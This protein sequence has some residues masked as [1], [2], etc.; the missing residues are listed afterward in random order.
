MSQ[1][2]LGGNMQKKFVVA[3][4]TALGI[5]TL[6]VGATG[7]NAAPTKKAKVSLCAGKTKAAAIKAINTAYASVLDGSKGLTGEQK[8]EFIQF[9]SGKKLNQAWRDAFLA[10]SAKNTGAAS[11]TSVA[12][13]KVT[14]TGKKSADVVFTLVLGGSRAEGLAPP[15][16]AVL[17][18]NTWK[19]SAI[20]MC[21]MQALGDATVLEN[22]PCLSIASS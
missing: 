20:T 2:Y 5:A 14:C 3:I 16:T 13:D 10:S 12:V 8:A 18:G 11:T 17:E 22:E 9:A 7:A 19:I 6:A 1:N 4:V 15:G 21:D